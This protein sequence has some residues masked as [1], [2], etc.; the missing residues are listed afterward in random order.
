MSNVSKSI[1]GLV[2]KIIM[3]EEEKEVFVNILRRVKYKISTDMLPKPL[4]WNILEKQ[5]VYGVI[6]TSLNGLRIAGIDGGVVTRYL[7]TFDLVITRAVAAIFH[8]SGDSLK[9]EY[10]PEKFPSPEILLDM[11]PS[12]IADSEINASLER[13][14]AELDVAMKLIDEYSVDV[15]LM[16]GSIIPQM[17]DRPPA[18]STELNAKYREIVTKYLELYDRCS[19]NDIL[20]AGVIKDSRS[21]RFMSILSRLLPHMIRQYPELRDLLRIDYRRIL[22]NFKDTDFLFRFLNVKER[23]TVFRFSEKWFESLSEM[24][25]D[26]EKKLREMF[27]IFYIKPAEFD[28]PL[29]IEF[30]SAGKDPGTIAERLSSIIYPLSSHHPEYALPSVLIEADAMAK[31]LETDLEIIYESLVNKIG[32]SPSLL[33]LRRERSPFF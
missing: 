4:T 22:L 3:L 2:R 9:V 33:R 6:P 20:L 17:S 29:R 11:A 15:I 8:F 21:S 18:Y 28:V 26:A 16:D 10:F 27:C 30:L 7:Q 14:R 19:E 12:S 5:F 31:I 1:E 32:F 24:G 13:V 25:I 23:T